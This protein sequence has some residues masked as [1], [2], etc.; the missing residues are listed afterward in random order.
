MCSED[1]EDP[2]AGEKIL[3]PGTPSDSIQLL[4]QKGDLRCKNFGLRI[5]HKMCFLLKN[6]VITLLNR[7]YML[8]R[9]WSVFLSVFLHTWYLKGSVK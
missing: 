7:G 9:I 5:A 3:G 2:G 1:D 6:D 4:Y 8:L